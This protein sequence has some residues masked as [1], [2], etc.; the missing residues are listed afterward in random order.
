MYIRKCT[1]TGTHI[2]FEHLK[3]IMNT[4]LYYKVKIP[5]VY[6]IFLNLMN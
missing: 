4:D 6:N 5:V 3:Y 2:V 1:T